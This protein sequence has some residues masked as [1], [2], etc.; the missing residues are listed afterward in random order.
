MDG[1]TWATRQR[2]IAELLSE[3]TICVSNREAGKDLLVGGGQKL[4]YIR[5]IEGSHGPV[6]ASDEVVKRCR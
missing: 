2:L 6:S 5:S 3:P 4:G 1:Q